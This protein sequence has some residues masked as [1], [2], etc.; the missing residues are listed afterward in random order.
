MSDNPRKTV[1]HSRHVA[2][3]AT[4]MD[5]AG[6]EMPLRY[7]GGIIE[8]HMAVRTGA[9]VFDVSH[10]G[11]F[12]IAGPGALPLLR[13]GL[14]NDAALLNVGTAHYTMI[15]T[16]TGGAVDDVYLYRTDENEFMLVGNAA[17]HEKDLAMLGEL[18]ARFGGVSTGDVSGKLA[19]LALQGPASQDV[20]LKLAEAGQ[21][22]APKRNLLSRVQLEGAEVIVSRTGYTGESTA[23]ELFMPAEAAGAVWDAL[24][25]AGARP[26]GLGA[27]DTLRL[28]AGLPLYGH[29]LGVD[30][31]GNEIPIFALKHAK[32]AVNFDDGTRDFVGR[33]ALETQAASL[34]RGIV[35]LAVRGR[36]AA[37]AGAVVYDAPEGGNRIGWVTSGTVVPHRAG[38]KT[39][40]RA[41]ALA[42]VDS[43][44]KAGETVFVEVRRRRLEAKLVRRHLKPTEAGHSEAVLHWHGR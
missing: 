40:L 27:R 14:S 35:P 22:P 31:E 32:Y 12:V 37:R 43:G 26:A 41:V 42:L 1:F 16:E 30:V 21:L 10:M 25:K 18:S 23:F 36:A 7:P 3:G 17:N 24:T 6:F 8:E 4:M 28:E 2:L 38:D 33:R 15:P 9:G 34:R 5:F 19:M 20:L 44:L 11:R 13:Y 39:V 29:E